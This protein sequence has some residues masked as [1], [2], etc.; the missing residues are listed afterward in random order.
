MRIW[1]VSAFAGLVLVA[2]ILFLRHDLRGWTP[3]DPRD[4][5]AIVQPVGAAGTA[6]AV[7]QCVPGTIDPWGTPTSA[8]YS[9]SATVTVLTCRSRSSALAIGLAAIAAAA[10]ALGIPAA[11]RR[12]RRTASR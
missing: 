6:F 5:A 7:G 3:A 11:L 9:G 12:R 1:S 2:A 4:P 8:E 10:I